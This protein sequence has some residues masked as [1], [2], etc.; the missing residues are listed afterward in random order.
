MICEITSTQGKASSH[1]W[2]NELP[3]DLPIPGAKLASHL[4]D[5][6]TH[7]GRGLFKSYAR[8]VGGASALLESHD[9]SVGL[10]PKETVCQLDRDK[11]YWP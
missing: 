4:L 7:L 9:V 6:T 3:M 10:T 11:G 8:M 1:S 5:T 2:T